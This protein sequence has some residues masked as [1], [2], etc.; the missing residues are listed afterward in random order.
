MGGNSEITPYEVNEITLMNQN[1]KI[2]T[3]LTEWE[4]L[5]QSTVEAPCSNNNK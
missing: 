5:R 1:H 2:E 3:I 4:Q